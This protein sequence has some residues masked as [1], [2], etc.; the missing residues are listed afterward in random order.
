MNRLT[1]LF[2]LFLRFS[3][4][5]RVLSY[6]LVNCCHNTL[7]TI[8]IN[9]FL[10]LLFTYILS[11]DSKC[12]LNVVVTGSSYVAYVEKVIILRSIERQ[13]PLTY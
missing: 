3:D 13:T 7:V 6:Y 11:V 2:D 4:V 12:V 5:G 10:C 1:L 8:G 9:P